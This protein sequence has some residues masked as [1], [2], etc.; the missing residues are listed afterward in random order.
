[1]EKNYTDGETKVQVS[2]YTGFKTKKVTNNDKLHE[3]RFKYTK[4]V[5]IMTNHYYKNCQCTFC[6]DCPGEGALR[7]ILF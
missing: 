7:L 2:R 5:I 4:Y 6:A 3:H 1:M